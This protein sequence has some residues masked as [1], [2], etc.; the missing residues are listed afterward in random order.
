M[1]AGLVLPLSFDFTLSLTR[2]LMAGSRVREG[3]LTLCSLSQGVCSLLGLSQ[4]PLSKTT[5]TV[6]L[7]FSRASGAQCKCRPTV[8]LPFDL[9][10]SLTRFPMVGS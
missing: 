7:F 3:N 5:A 9:T 6:F 2:F 1:S 10:L 4:S 8:P